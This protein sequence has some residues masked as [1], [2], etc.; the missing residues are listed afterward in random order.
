MIGRDAGRAGGDRLAKYAALA[1]TLMVALGAA[2]LVRAQP[3]ARTACVSSVFKLC[4]SAA[5]RGDRTAA[6]TCLLKNLDRAT[7][8][9]QAA[10]KRLALAREDASGK[11]A[12]SPLGN[13][14]P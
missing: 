6:K 5:L 10:I 8:E 3:E 7:P 1:L 2:S 9:C 11:P 12:A 14:P 13:S 4:P